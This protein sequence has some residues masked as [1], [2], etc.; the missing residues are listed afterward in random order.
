MLRNTRII[1]DLS[2]L[3]GKV[4]VEVRQEGDYEII[5]SCKDGTI[6]RML[7]ESDCCEQVY[8]DEVIGELSWLEGKPITMAERVQSEPSEEENNA[9]G[10]YDCSSTWTF[11]KFATIKGYVTIKWYGTSNGYYSEDADIYEAKAVY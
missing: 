10:Y 8:I 5:F 4:F 11:F 3:I 1:T 7:H 2:E 9:S 6:Y